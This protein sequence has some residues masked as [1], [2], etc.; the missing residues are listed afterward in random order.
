MLYYIAD[1]WDSFILYNWNISLSNTSLFPSLLSS[2]NHHSILCCYSLSTLFFVFQLFSCV[3]LFVTPWSVAHQVSLPFTISQSLLKHMSI[4]SLMPFNHLIHC[5]PLLLLPSI[6]PTIRV[7]FNE[8]AL[9]IRWPK[10]WS[11]GF[12]IS[13]SIE[14]SGLISFR[15]DWFDFRESQESSPTPQF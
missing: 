4:E 1:L 15:T 6:F 3:Q 13:P 8:L 10:Y 2:G 5:H 7:F 12:S 9:H 11:F 14:Y